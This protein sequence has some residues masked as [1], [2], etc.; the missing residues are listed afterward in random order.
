MTGSFR[1]LVNSF[2]SFRYLYDS[3]ERPN[4]QM[5]CCRHSYRQLLSHSFNRQVFGGEFPPARRIVFYAH[6]DRHG[7]D[8]PHCDCTFCA[9]ADHDKYPKSWHSV[10]TALVVRMSNDR[11]SNIKRTFIEHPVNTADP[12]LF[13]SRVTI[14]GGHG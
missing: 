5:A 11:L 2:Y 12:A 8:E 1:D 10:S 13:G 4:E 9:W 6:G 3:R 7:P 14:A